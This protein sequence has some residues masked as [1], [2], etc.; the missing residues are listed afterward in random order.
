MIVVAGG[1]RSATSG[2]SAVA[3]VAHRVAVLGAGVEAVGVVPADGIGDRLLLE[4]R[5]AGVG[6]AAVLRSPAPAL[7]A[8]DLDL[9]LRY[10]PDIRAIVLVQPDAELI[11]TASASAV[12]LGAG[13]VIV[14][15]D[16]G[17]LP[18]D[19]PGVERSVVLAPPGADPDGAFAG[20]VAVLAVGLARGDAPAEAWAEATTALG[21]EP[22]SGSLSS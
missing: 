17:P 11:A 4:L 9:A 13:L 16:G 21:V 6:H 10:L 8:A 15:S 20:F 2:P 18:V 19:G 3:T 5:S 7:E 12:W 14:T 1:L 22:V